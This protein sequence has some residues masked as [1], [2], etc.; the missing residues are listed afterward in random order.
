M[1]AGLESDPARVDA[2]EEGLR[3]NQA[4]R[5]EPVVELENVQSGEG[6]SS[7]HADKGADKRADK[8]ADKSSNK[9]ADKG[10]SS[11]QTGKRAG[12]QCQLIP[13]NAANVAP[14]KRTVKGDEWP[15]A[16]H[17]LVADKL[18]SV[19]KGVEESNQSE[20]EDIL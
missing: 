1:K 2:D 7:L 14:G 17:E 5:T 18:P 3:L 19:T 8:R 4:A 20:D 15:T 11:L 9:G 13:A 12:K 10:A 6:T 16:A